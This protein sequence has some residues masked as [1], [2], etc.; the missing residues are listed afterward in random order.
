MQIR[1]WWKNPIGD[2][3][4]KRGEVVFMNKKLKSQEDIEELF[5]ESMNIFKKHIE[6]LTDA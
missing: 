3:L 2:V 1:I 6:G 5:K 4:Q